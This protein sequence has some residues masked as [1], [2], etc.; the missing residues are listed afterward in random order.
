MSARAVYTFIEKGARFNVYKHH[1]GY[2]SGALDATKAALA[3]AWPLPR[4][5]ACDMAAAFVAGNKLKG[6]GGVYLMP[7]GAPKTVAPDDIEYRYIIEQNGFG[8]RELHATVF[9]TNYWEAKRIEWRIFTGTLSEMEKWIDDGHP[10][11]TGLKIKG[12]VS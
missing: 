1:D 3:F 8:S 7:G 5:E 12:F 10:L 4:Y 2:P 11:P 6:G 9:K